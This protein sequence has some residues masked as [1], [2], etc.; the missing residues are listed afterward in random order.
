[1]GT[2]PDRWTDEQLEAI[3]DDTGHWAVNGQQ[4]RVPG[5]GVSLRHAINRYYEFGSSGAVV[6]SVRRRSPDNIV[7]LPAQVARLQKI[8]AT[9]E[10]EAVASWLSR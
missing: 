7:V 8:I 6:T 5:F 1:M 4:E 2:R 10:I 3:L 9:Q